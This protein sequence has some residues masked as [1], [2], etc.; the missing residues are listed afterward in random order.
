MAEGMSRGSKEG[1]FKLYTH[2]KARM[3]QLEEENRHLQSVLGD[4]RS[5]LVA[6]QG[7][8][9]LLAEEWHKALVT[10]IDAALPA[11]GRS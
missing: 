11:R 5:I 6:R 10:I 1:Y 2:Q 8:P 9:P 4:M 7:Q 3:T